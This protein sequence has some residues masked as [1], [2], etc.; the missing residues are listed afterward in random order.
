MEGTSSTRAVFLLG[1]GFDADAIYKEDDPRYP[2]VADTARLCFDLYRP[3]SDKSVEDLFSEAED[4]RPMEKLADR[5]MEADHYQAF[6]LAKSEAPNPYREFFERFAGNH[7]LT[8]NYD[9]LPETLLFRTGRWFPH[10]GY[11][12]P[13]RTEL[14]PQ[15]EGYAAEKSTSLVLHLH[16]SFCVKTSESE[17]TRKQGDAMPWLVPREE[18]AY[19]FDPYLISLNFSYVRPPGGFVVEDRIIAPVKDKSKGLKGRFVCDVYDK[20]FICTLTRVETLT[21]RPRVAGSISLPLFGPTNQLHWQGIS[22]RYGSGSL[23]TLRTS[24]AFTPTAI[25]RSAS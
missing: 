1:A 3:P 23:R 18:P 12:V 16:G 8:F 20:A 19:F 11:G 9:S 13:V 7:F 24:S 5:L 10:D 2:L 22:W 25:R 17:I 15:A 21:F 14:P 6:Q 4:Y